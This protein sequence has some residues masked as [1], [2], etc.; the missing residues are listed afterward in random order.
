MKEFMKN[1]DFKNLTDEEKLKKREEM[2]AAFMEKAQK[3]QEEKKKRHEEK[4]KI[5]YE[6]CRNDA[7]LS[8]LM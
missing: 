7:E 2:K 1:E 8:Q 6:K 5:F 3:F 4:R